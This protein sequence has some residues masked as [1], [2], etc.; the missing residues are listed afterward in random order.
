MANEQSQIKQMQ[1]MMGKY[2]IELSEFKK[3]FQELQDDVKWLYEN[4]A[5]RDRGEDE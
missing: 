4:V 3:Q 1:A 5:Y 2:L